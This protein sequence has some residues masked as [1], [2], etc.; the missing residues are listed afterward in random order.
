MP[1]ESSR[2]LQQARPF[3]AHS[4]TPGDAADWQPLAD[5]LQAVGR[6]AQERAQPLGLG[7]AASCAGLLHDLGKYHPDVQRRIAG[8]ELRVDHSTA[9]AVALIQAAAAA[10]VGDRIAAEVLAYC[11]LGHHAGLPDR[12]NGTASS[13][14]ARVD[15]FRDGLDPAW[16]Q[17]V[18]VDLSGIAAELQARAGPGNLGFD[19]SVATRMVFSCLVDADFLD[20]EAF[21]AGLG[22]CEV[23]RNWP[24]LQE[25]L[26]D[27]R[28]AFDAHMA[29]LGQEGDLNA[30]RRGILEHVRDAAALAPGLFTL[31]VPTGGGKTLASL[32]FALDHAARHGHRRIIYAI[33]FTSIIDQT[34][35]IF[36]DLL[37]A[38]AVLEH[39]SAIDE[40][41]VSERAGR[42][43]LRLAMETWAAPVVVTT[44]VQL[45][46]SLF[47]ARPSRARKLHGIAGSI[48]ILDEAQNLPRLLLRPCLAMLDC[49][50]RH[51]G[52]TIVFCTATQPAVQAALKTGAALDLRELAPD[53]AGLE[54]R[55]RRARIVDRAEMDNPALVEALEGVQ[56]GFVIVNSRRHALDLYR[57]ARSAGIGDLV[58]LT[59]RQTAAHR[60][61]ILSDIRRRLQ[62]CAPCRLIATSLIEAG[63]DLDFPTGW[64]ARA[65]LDQV[66]QAAGRV[67]REGRRPLEESVLTVFS[68]P[69]Y[70]VPR[71]IQSLIGDLERVRAVRGEDVQSLEAIEAYFG[72]VYWRMKDRLDARR[73][74]DRL[75][76]SV[77]QGTD[78]AFRSIAEEF[79]LI[80][81]AM[82]PVVIPRDAAAEVSRLRCADVPSGVLARELQRHVVLVPQKARMQLVDC[83]KASFVA[84]DLRGD[85]FCRRA[86]PLPRSSVP[87]DRDDR[88]G[89]PFDDG[90]V[91]A[92]GVIG[93]VGGHSADLLV[94]RNLV[95]QIGQDRAVAL[96][97]GGEFH[98]ADVRCGRV[99]RQMHLAPLAA[100]LDAVLAS[101]PQRKPAQNLDRQAELDRGIG[102]DRRAP[103]AP[104]MRRKPG[105]LLAQPDQ[106]GAALSQ[107]RVV[108]GPVRRAVA[109]G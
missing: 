109:G 81:T 87:S 61:D 92:A 54:H 19:L 98:G 1:E 21:Y 45:F 2:P 65:G 97:A 23:D 37:G 47:A 63:V 88:G 46:E 105:H 18:S 43:K 67:N 107:R 44:N 68:C 100:P 33:P 62:E 27:Y 48:L 29:G 84:P 95:E 39:H 90:G 5:H 13:M 101:L 78:F 42:D 69:G 20:T 64:R 57:A 16:R 36:R 106:Q 55:L 32:G 15:G 24:E 17:Q 89:L 102:E 83:G 73:V 94:L 59:T 72:E 30:L 74:L 71:D 56:Q 91:A 35:R 52:C 103:R 66:I 108:A 28:A 3:W 75:H 10:A 26:P 49:L 53:P 70:P 31:T 4:G 99:H 12:R 40:E 86:V 22:A 85:Q 25:R 93:P 7:R 82:L 79:R 34:A 58:H 76:L 9:G 8:A 6:L 14:Q 60:Q 38:E 41:S 77:G 11:I 50:A 104:L 51:W 80:E 96:A